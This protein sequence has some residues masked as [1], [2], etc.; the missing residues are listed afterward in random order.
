MQE[1][2]PMAFTGPSNAQKDTTLPD[3]GCDLVPPAAPPNAPIKDAAFQDVETKL[4]GLLNRTKQFISTPTGSA[5]LLEVDSFA[6][7]PMVLKLLEQGQQVR[8]RFPAPEVSLSD[9]D[10]EAI[11]DEQKK[12]HEFLSQRHNQPISASTADLTS[13]IKDS[14]LFRALDEAGK[15]SLV[16]WLTT[17]QGPNQTKTDTIVVSHIYTPQALQSPEKKADILAKL[18]TSSSDSSP[19]PRVIFEVPIPPENTAGV[20]QV[21]EALK[22]MLDEA[23]SRAPQGFA[24]Q[25]PFSV[26]VGEAQILSGPSTV[27]SQQQVF[28]VADFFKRYIDDPASSPPSASPGASHSPSSDTPPLQPTESKGGFWTKAVEA[29][30]WPLRQFEKVAGFNPNAAT[31]TA[32]TGASSPSSDAPAARPTESKGGFWSNAM[33]AP[34]WPLRQFEKLA[35]FNPNA[36]VPTAPTD[37]SLAGNDTP[38]TAPDS[39]APSAAAVSGASDANWTDSLQPPAISPEGPDAMLL[40]GVSGELPPVAAEE[41]TSGSPTIEPATGRSLGQANRELTELVAAGRFGELGGTIGYIT[42]GL[43]DIRNS[44]ISKIHSEEDNKRFSG[45]WLEHALRAIS[46]QHEPC[47]TPYVA[48]AR[49]ETASEI[50]NFCRERSLMDAVQL[51]DESFEKLCEARGGT[52]AENPLPVGHAVSQQGDLVRL[53]SKGEMFVLSDLEGNVEAVVKLIEE[54][55]LLERWKN[56]EPVFLVVAGDSVDRSQQGSLL[57][58]FLLELKFRRGIGDGIIILPGNHELD[59][60][61]HIRPGRLGE[62]YR[63]L[64][65]KDSNLRSVD[66]CEDIFRRRYPGFGADAINDPVVQSA[67]ADCPSGINLGAQGSL[68]A[69]QNGFGMQFEPSNNLTAEERQLDEVLYQVRWGIYAKFNKVFRVLPKVAKAYNGALVTHAGVPLTGAFQGIYEGQASAPNQKPLEDELANL[70]HDNID[71]VTWPDIWPPLDTEDEKKKLREYY[72]TE[73]QKLESGLGL[74]EA[75]DIAKCQADLAQLEKDFQLFNESGGLVSSVVSRKGYAIPVYKPRGEGWL[76]ISPTANDRA[77]SALGASLRIG[78]HQK[79]EEP[80]SFS[81]G[82]DSVPAGVGHDLLDEYPDACHYLPWKCGKAV[83]LAGD[84]NKTWVASVDLSRER[85]SPDDVT[86]FYVKISD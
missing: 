32:S 76:G 15:D 44:E 33:K 53:P 66:L 3:L 61:Q 69:N 31:S 60:S 25:A 81:L 73:R 13:L 19:A 34:L 67:L 30:L 40:A 1:Y 24:I 8:L 75:D 71:E 20:R 83:V 18:A 82:R 46:T 59:M 74:G 58:E 68:V 43:L 63:W 7:V 10:R 23:Q 9:A 57:V 41:P 86:C 48:P 65:N 29:P 49:G 72:E 2:R 5:E 27:P 21:A 52:R 79:R 85:P 37:G 62:E 78:G 54:K 4:Q 50:L 22:A 6:Q 56:D 80:E 12:I 42:K 84:R 39:T 36:V 47:K 51:L 55:K 16:N 14:F 77:L 11:K 26:W 64:L 28:P 35:G 17:T 38:I 45:R 70:S